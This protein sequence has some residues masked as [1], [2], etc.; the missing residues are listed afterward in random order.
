MSS[1]SRRPPYPG[2]RGPSAQAAGAHGE[3]GVPEGTAVSTLK[4]WTTLRLT[5]AAV[6]PTHGLRAIEAASLYAQAVQSRKH[7]ARRGK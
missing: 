6:V 4:A 7:K 5:L 1:L 2:T 3:P